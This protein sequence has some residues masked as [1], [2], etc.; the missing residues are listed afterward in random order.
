MD[1]LR[2][3]QPSVAQ[4]QQQVQAQQAR[5]VDEWRTKYKPTEQEEMLVAG[6]AN[7]HWEAQQRAAGRPA[8]LD[9]ALDFVRGTRGAAPA[10]KSKAPAAIPVRRVAPGGRGPSGAPQA[11]P[12]A[13]KAPSAGD[14][15]H[16]RPVLTP[17]QIKE[18]REKW[19]FGL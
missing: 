5:M 17:E 2:E 3:V 15:T 7:T 10:V 12:P 19:G 9:A 11:P 4:V 1:V 18:Q 8:T 6:L 13:P 14:V 16:W